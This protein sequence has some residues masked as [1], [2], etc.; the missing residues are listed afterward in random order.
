[1]SPEPKRNVFSFLVFLLFKV[2]GSETEDN[3]GED[4]KPSSPGTKSNAADDREA[5]KPARITRKS[6]KLDFLLFR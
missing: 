6:C 1:M 3:G 2:A 4:S 5:A